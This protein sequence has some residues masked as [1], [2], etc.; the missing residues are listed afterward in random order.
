MTKGAGD[1]GF[2]LRPLR[3]PSGWTVRHNNFVDVPLENSYWDYDGVVL[4]AYHAEWDL[5]IDLAWR[6]GLASDPRAERGAFVLQVMN[7]D[8]SGRVLSRF[9]SGDPAAVAMEL[10]RLFADMP[11]RR[12]PG[13][14]HADYSSGEVDML[15]QLYKTMLKLRSEDPAFDAR[16]QISDV[17]VEDKLMAVAPMAQRYWQG[18]DPEIRAGAFRIETHLCPHVLRLCDW[19][20]PRRENENELVAG[21][22]AHFRNREA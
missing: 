3:I 19:S 21:L 16:V 8:R 13:L 22:D 18:L 2:S 1:M 17:W 20:H 7:D 6:A 14:R 9:E 11:A 4:L 12:A 15:M 5:L 10:D